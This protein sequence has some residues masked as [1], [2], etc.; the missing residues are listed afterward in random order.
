MLLDSASL[1]RL[2]RPDPKKLLLKQFNVRTAL[3]LATKTEDLLSRLFD[4]WYSKDASGVLQEN[5]N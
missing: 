2:A 4:M 1:G 3:K 5:N